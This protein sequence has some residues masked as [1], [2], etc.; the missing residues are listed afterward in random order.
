[1]N[2]Q[3]ESRS[4][5][6]LVVLLCFGGSRQNHSGTESADD[7]GSDE[8]DIFEDTAKSHRA[9]DRN[10]FALGKPAVNGTG[11]RSDRG[12]RTKSAIDHQEQSKR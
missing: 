8:A 11:T 5:R 2:R 12:A 7:T 4:G 1:M 9:G 3:C 6:S 10:T